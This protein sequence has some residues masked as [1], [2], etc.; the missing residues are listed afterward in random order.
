[1]VTSQTL[2]LAWRI[3]R[4][5]LVTSSARGARSLR[6]FAIR[7]AADEQTSKLAVEAGS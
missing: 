4:G 3:A 1:M 6:A 2:V 5:R 7:Q